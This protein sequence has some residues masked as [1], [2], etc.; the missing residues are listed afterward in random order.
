MNKIISRS[1]GHTVDP[2]DLSKWEILTASTSG[3]LIV[4]LL[5]SERLKAFG[6][7]QQRN[8]EGT[9]H[10]ARCGKNAEAFL[11]CGEK[12]GSISAI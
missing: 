2:G 8:D 7:S 4:I 6:G 1:D 12:Y 9:A 10:L 5:F 11:F 3:G